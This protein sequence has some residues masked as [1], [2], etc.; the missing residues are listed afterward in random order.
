MQPQFEE[1]LDAAAAA[2]ISPSN[3][4]DSLIRGRTVTCMVL[5]QDSVTG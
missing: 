2:R 1:L 5:Q 4:Y 3:A